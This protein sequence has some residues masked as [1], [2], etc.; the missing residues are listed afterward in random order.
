[1]MKM[2]TSTL[3]FALAFALPGYAVAQSETPPPMPLEDQEAIE[4]L[5]KGLDA[6]KGLEAATDAA[7]RQKKI[8]A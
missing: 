3:F 8:N 4:Q 1:M 2:R 6:I 7:T 5:N